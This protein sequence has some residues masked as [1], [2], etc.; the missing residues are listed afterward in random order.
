MLVFLLPMMAGTILQSLSMTLNS[1]FVGRLIGVHGLAAISAFFPVFFFLI[2]FVIGLSSGSSVLVGQAHGA[3]DERRVR[4]IAGT[5]LSLCVVLGIL[6]G[7]LGSLLAE[8]LLRATGTPPD[9]LP[10][11]IQYARIAFVGIPLLFFYLMYTTLMRG[12]GDTTTPLYFLIASTL[13]GMAFTPALIL[14]WGGLP[15]LGVD[16]AIVSNLLATLLTQ[17]GLF[18]YLRARNHPLRLCMEMVRDFVPDGRLVASILHIG[19]PAGIQVML[20]SLAEI[21]VLAFVNGFGSGATA[22]YGA[23]N[24]VVNYIQFPAITLSITAS[25]FCAQAIGAR[26]FDRVGEIARAAVLLNYAIVGSLIVLGYAL[27]KQLLSLFLGNSPTVGIARGLLDITLWSYVIFGNSS[28]LSG[29]MRASRTVVWPTAISVFSIWAVEVPIAYV[30]SRRIGLDG[31]WI[32]YPVAYCTMLALQ[33]TFYFR[34]WK[35]REL[36][37]LA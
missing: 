2:S 11:T 4:R 12:V 23:V 9:I 3:Q 27:D 30:L 33:T 20:L 21:A 29:V 24:Q 34:I 1:I 10:A 31:V 15:R 26:R 6:V 8:P 19:I 32:G 22:A 37:A 35:R 16:S 14:G 25:I 36:R 13:L 5:A 17:I 18:F 28:V 7:L